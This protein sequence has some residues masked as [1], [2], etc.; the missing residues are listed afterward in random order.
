MK[1]LHLVL[2]PHQH[3]H[4]AQY[5]FILL[6]ACGVSVCLCVYVR[7][8]ILF[9]LAF[10]FL[11]EVFN[12]LLALK[13]QHIFCWCLNFPIFFFFRLLKKKLSLLLFFLTQRKLGEWWKKIKGFLLNT[14]CS[15]N[16]TEHGDE[17]KRHAV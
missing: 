10:N 3:T 8:G 4:I 16:K 5:I 11:E 12:M 2:R 7:K 1:W 9:P 6:C 13:W 14:A 17:Q 15:V